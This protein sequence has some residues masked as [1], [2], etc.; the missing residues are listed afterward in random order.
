MEVAAV[1][2][3][4]V[5]VNDGAPGSTD[6]GH[7]PGDGRS[8]GRSRDDRRSSAGRDTRDQHR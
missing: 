7:R 6:A 8:G 1:V 3:M 4:D 5:A 2:F